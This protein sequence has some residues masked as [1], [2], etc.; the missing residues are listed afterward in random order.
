MVVPLIVQSV[1]DEAG[2]SSACARRKPAW[3]GAWDWQDVQLG[4]GLVLGLV[5]GSGFTALVSHAWHAHHHA[6]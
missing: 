3:R 5:L 4:L 6:P 1:D 2:P